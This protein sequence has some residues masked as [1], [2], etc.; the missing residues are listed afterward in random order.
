M[1]DHDVSRALGAMQSVSVEL[2]YTRVVDVWSL[3]AAD[4][5]QHQMSVRHQFGD[6]VFPSYLWQ[7]R[8][9]PDYG[10]GRINP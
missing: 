9:A 1:V 4:C 5:S 6:I 2:L 10:L 3:L 8:F 7:A